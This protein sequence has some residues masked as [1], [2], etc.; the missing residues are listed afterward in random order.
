VPAS[1]PFNPFGEPLDWF[2]RLLNLGQRKEDVVIDTYR[3]I[4]GI[5]IINLPQNWFVDANF[6][7]AE[8]DA[9]KDDFNG[10]LNNRL[11]EALSGTLPGFAGQYLNP[12]IDTGRNPNQQFINALRYDSHTTART[13]LTQWTIRAGG[14]LFYLPSGALTVGGGAEYRSESYI[15]VQD[16]NL[17]IHNLTGAGTEQNSQGKD[18][19][20]SIYGQ[21]IIPI[22]G[23]QWSWPGARLL[24]VDLSERYDSYS[25]F[26]D[27][28]KPKIAVRYKPLDDLTFR[29]AYSESFRAPSLPELFSGAT[30]GFLTIT[31]PQIAPPNNNYDVQVEGLGNPHLKPETGYSY[32]TGA[33]WS[34][35]SADP[36]HSWWGWANGFT[37]YV[38]WVEISRRNV[39]AE[40]SPQF[41][42]DHPSAYPGDIIRGAGGMIA[43]VF[44]PFSN[45]GAVRVDAIDF[46][47][48]YASKEYGWGKVALEVDA[49]YLYHVSEQD[50]PGGQVLNVTDSLGGSIY[51][52]PD[53]KLV[54]SAFYSKTL[55]GI[56]TFKT[57][58]VFNYVDSEHDLNDFRAL[59]LTL[60]EFVAQTGFPQVHTVG[61]W[62]TVDWQIGYEFGKPEIVTPEAPKAGYDKEGK[63]IV[64]EKAVAPQPEA[65][66][67]GIRTWLAGTKLTFGIKNIF[68]TRPPF[69]D[70]QAGFDT[71]NATPFGRYFYVEI[72]KKF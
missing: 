10:T 71:A 60:Q 53:F 55:F 62:I 21:I 35:G 3:N 58:V 5:R 19:V 2:G 31:D 34:P 6:L 8:S 54:A 52:G 65:A 23:G 40:P 12:F 13:D 39:I 36:E 63:K 48:S 56:D 61:N 47:A 51:T 28:A 72:E 7:Y 42:I 33:V 26:G 18:Y 44:T 57:G 46:G 9:T 20:K 17:N 24:E 43:T 45:L 66:N 68:D 30:S 16:P 4:G 15:A 32:Y 67:G 22:L 29:A 49:S 27:A 14:D 70:S 50:I 1:N 25:S 69:E 37:A 11:N 59:G 64:G 41:V 38:D